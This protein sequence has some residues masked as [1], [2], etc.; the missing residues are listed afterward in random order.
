[1]TLPNAIVL[2]VAKAG[3]TSLYHY[4]RQHPQVEVSR[5][6]EPKFLFY[7]G[8]L[9]QPVSRTLENFPVRSLRQYEALYTGENP[10]SARVD[11]SPIY[12]SRPEQTILGI[13]KYVPDAKLMIIYRQP[14]DRA[15][16]AFLMQVREGYEPLQDFTKALEAEAAGW[17]SGNRYRR[18]YLSGSWYAD[19][20][21]KLLEA[22]PKDQFRFLLYDDFALQPVLFMQDVFRILAVDPAYPLQI[23]IQHN[24][25][26]W[27]RHTALHRLLSLRLRVPRKVRAL[28]PSI[29]RGQ[30]VS[31]IRSVGYDKPP[32]LD[33]DLRRTLTNRF[34]EDI[35]ELQALIDRD[36]SGWFLEPVERGNSAKG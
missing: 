12:F 1:M 18:H 22:F 14:V 13:R 16:S 28:V 36:L 4:L 3:T 20:T 33:G 29:L 31:S 15:Y 2:G 30:L 35:L 26:V 25:G 23:T 34:R 19:R 9:Q 7:A 24:A 5:I 17:P 27:P 32:P 10:P 21:R 8:N 11:I 6:R